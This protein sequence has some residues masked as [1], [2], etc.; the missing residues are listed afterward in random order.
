MCVSAAYNF[1]I[2]SSSPT[3]FTAVPY[4]GTAR[5]GRLLLSVLFT[6]HF[7]AVGRKGIHGVSYYEIAIS[8]RTAPFM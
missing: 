8:I 6:P 3:P 5:S 4:F 1:F 2:I 7:V